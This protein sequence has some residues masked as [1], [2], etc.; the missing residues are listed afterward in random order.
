[1]NKRSKQRLIGV[2][3]LVLLVVAGLLYGASQGIG[4]GAY[5][6]SIAEIVESEEFVGKQVQVEGPVVPGSW[7]PG[8][9]PLVFD[10]RPKD[11]PNGPT[12]TIVWD[13]STPSAF[14]D[15]TTAIVTGMVNPDKTVQAKTLITQCPSKYASAKDALTVDAI[16]ASDLVGTPTK[17][18]G[19]V[20]DGTVAGSGSDVRF[21]LGTNSSGETT[22]GI[23][24]ADALPDGVTDGAKL[25][26][27][28][29][30]TKDGRFEARE[31]ALD[32]AD[33]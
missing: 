6:A 30:L 32:E 31:I 19:Y 20:V 25:V 2:T 13:G 8:S 14:G 21:V 1:M 3:I 18:T 15:G 10:I 29:T 24:W 27:E 11:D 12:L 22:I 4:Q 26:I 17:I 16:L 33:R 23:M 9:K 28:G 7:T 5:R